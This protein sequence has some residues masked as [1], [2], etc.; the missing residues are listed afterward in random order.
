[1]NAHVFW[2]VPAQGHS[3]DAAA[4]VACR[5]LAASALVVFE[6]KLPTVRSRQGNMFKA[7]SGKSEA[8]PIGKGWGRLL[9]GL[10]KNR[11]EGVLVWLAPFF[12]G[13]EQEQILLFPP[14]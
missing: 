2:I 13:L 8:G 6:D 10:N 11:G 3:G 4:E 14:S 12:F 5:S 7:S 9:F 1:M